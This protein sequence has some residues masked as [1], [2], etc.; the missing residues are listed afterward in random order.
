MSCENL[1]K[2]YII[3]KK[4]VSSYF[5]DRGHG[6]K[7]GQKTPLIFAKLLRAHVE[8]MSTFR[9]SRMLMK[10]NELKGFFQDVYE[11][12]GSYLKCLV[13]VY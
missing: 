6:K 5:C 12:K 7:T 10:S 3:E 9:L 2:T 8:K 1:S 4:T 11:K 13:E